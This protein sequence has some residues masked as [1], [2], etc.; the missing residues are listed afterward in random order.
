MAAAGRPLRL[1]KPRLN[2]SDSHQ[3]QRGG[4][5]EG[6]KKLKPR[7]NTDTAP[8]N[9]P[10]RQSCHHSVYSSPPKRQASYENSLLVPWI[11]R[12]SEGTEEGRD[13]SEVISSEWNMIRK[14]SV[15]TKTSQEDNLKVC[16]NGVIS[17]SLRPWQKWVTLLLEGDKMFF[18]HFVWPIFTT[19]IS[20]LRSLRLRLHFYP[21]PLLAKGFN[22]GSPPTS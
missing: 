2:L 18:P 19:S 4:E 5:P 14:K 6:G 22:P 11:T 9:S 13:R 7:L 10:G 8:H 16:F 17:T 1:H 12:K 20:P 21:P 3:T 15:F